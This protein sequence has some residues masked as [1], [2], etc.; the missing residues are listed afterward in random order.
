MTEPLHM[1]TTMPAAPLPHVARIKG[2]LIMQ[3]ASAIMRELR[4]AL[5][6]HEH[7]LCDLSEVE[8]IDV[9][10]LQLLL[11]ACVTQ[12]SKGRTLT[13]HSASQPVRELYASFGL[14]VENG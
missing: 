10:G 9:I 12:R 13:Y 5:G 14:S 11:A 4:E 6:E 2:Q 3:R 8:T 7:V 1:H